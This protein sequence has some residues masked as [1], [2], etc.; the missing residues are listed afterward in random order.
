MTTI[1][2]EDFPKEPIEILKDILSSKEFKEIAS[3]NQ[4]RLRC[5]AEADGLMGEAIEIE[6]KLLAQLNKIRNIE[7]EIMLKSNSPKM[8]EADKAC[9][10][11]LFNDSCIQESAEVRAYK[12]GLL[13]LRKE[14]PEECHP[15]NKLVDAFKQYSRACWELL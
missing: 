6:S 1:R 8:Q 11:E 14:Y 5:M 4:E 2:K 15:S 13:P 3:L 12:A 7:A 9:S 10:Y